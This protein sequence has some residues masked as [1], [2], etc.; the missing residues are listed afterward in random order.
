[1]VIFISCNLFTSNFIS[2]NKAVG[3][4][5]DD[6]VKLDI[7]KPKQG[8]EFQ[9]VHDHHGILQEIFQLHKMLPCIYHKS[10]LDMKLSNKSL[11][12]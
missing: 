8:Y 1:M 4:Y 10:F 11:Q 3:K 6:H 2:L 9:I 12:I 7:I 5:H